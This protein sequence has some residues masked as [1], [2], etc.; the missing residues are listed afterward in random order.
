M[1]CWRKMLGIPWK[2]HRTNM[3]ILQELEIQ[4]RLSVICQTTG[5]SPAHTMSYELP[6]EITW[7]VCS[8]A[9]LVDSRSVLDHPVPSAPAPLV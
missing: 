2:V 4:T 6:T 7:L 9:P 5:P 8:E 1:W 3:S